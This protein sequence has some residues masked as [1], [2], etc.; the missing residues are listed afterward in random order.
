VGKSVFRYLLIGAVLILIFGFAT[1]GFSYALTD[2]YG[3][4]IDNGWTAKDALGFLGTSI[5]G[6]IAMNPSL[7]PTVAAGAL[8]AYI[9]Y[10]SAQLYDIYREWKNVRNGIALL[11]PVEFSQS[12][13]VKTVPAGEYAWWYMKVA[14]IDT[15]M[16][17]TPWKLFFA[18]KEKFNNNGLLESSYSKEIPYYG[19]RDGCIYKINCWIQD[20]LPQYKDK[21]G[22]SMF[23]AL[24]NAAYSNLVAGN[25]F[26]VTYSRD[27]VVA[28]ESGLDSAVDSVLGYRVNVD[29]QDIS[30]D[31]VQYLDDPDAF[32]NWFLTNYMNSVNEGTFVTPLDEAYDEIRSDLETIITQLN[33]L[34]SIGGGVSSETLEQ[35]KTDIINRVG[36]LESSLNSTL[37]S[38]SSSVNT[39][40][41]DVTG[42]RTSMDALDSTLTS[43]SSSLNTL[44]T[45]VTGVRTSIDAL[46]S[47]LTS[48]SSSLN[49]LQTDV[50][51]V[52]TSIDGLDSTL[53]ALSNSV[54]TL[55]AD[56]TDVITSIDALTTE[57]GEM[58][59]EEEGFWERLMEW[60]D[61]NLWERLQELLKELFLPTEEQLE[62]LFDIEVPEYEQ[63]F[64]AEVSITS[65][66]ASIPMSL[67]GSSVDLSDYIDDY[68]SGLRS[69]MN[70][71][72]C[73]IAAI[74]VIRA[75]RVYFH[76]D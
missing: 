29:P 74:F 22:R 40:Q 46:D 43:L 50:T 58:Q 73:G 20:E 38:L 10:K 4:L 5:A 2:A 56:V 32:Y 39:L 13:S 76:I 68:A 47:T 24:L 36:A 26:S 41:T 61:V 65:Q 44:E 12:M 63:N 11:N 17:Y 66:S 8:S 34:S 23:S 42:V 16:Y 7:A 33:N 72:V 64:A 52:R 25:E 1:K 59:E 53:T 14:V 15:G 6:T 19:S 69:F 71:F 27:V 21:Q 51:G 48:L 60:L 67:F 62:S 75:F 9:V 18:Y 28:L 49:T 3:L 55:Q 57:I 54:N 30:E 37:T 45:D 35:F 31:G 70:I